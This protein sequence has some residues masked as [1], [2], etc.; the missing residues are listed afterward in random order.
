M[1]FMGMKVRNG[2]FDL[3]DLRIDQLR[4]TNYEVA[5]HAIMK[6]PMTSLTSYIEAKAATQRSNGTK[7][8]PM[9]TIVN[10]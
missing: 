5:L 7:C 1:E 6:W 3:P 10:P 4:F 9:H 2:M 8:Q